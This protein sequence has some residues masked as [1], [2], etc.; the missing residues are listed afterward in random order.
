MQ[1]AHSFVYY[2]LEVVDVGAL[3]CR[4][5]DAIVRQLGEPRCLEFIETDVLAC[6]G[7]EVILFLLHI[8]K[9]IHLIKDNHHRLVAA[10]EVGQRF[11][12]D[13]NLILELG[14]RYIHHVQE[15]V[16]LTH[17][18]EGR[19]ER[20]NKVGGQ[21]AYETNG[22]GKQERKVLYN[23]LAHR[24][25]ER[26]KQFV[27]GKHFTLGKQV[28]KSGFTHVGIAHKRHANKTAAVLALNGL[29]AVYLC[30]LLLEERHTAQDYTAVHFELRLTRTAK[31]HATALA[32][33]RAT[34]LTFQV[35][36]QALQAWKHIFVLRQL[37]LH[38]G[39]GGLRT[40]SKDIQDER[41][42]VE[43]LYFK[44]LFDVAQLLGRQLVVED[45]HTYLL[46]GILAHLHIFGYLYELTTA[47]VCCRVRML[48]ALR[49]TFYHLGTCSLSKKF[50]LVEV[51]VGFALVLCGC[52]EAHKNGC[53]LFGG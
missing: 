51:L 52:Y 39:V 47:N 8:C 34:T 1:F 18:V 17:L 13:G 20:L 2:I 5:E 42:A 40:H 9:G 22:V 43:Y 12:N 46:I 33:T 37:H 15:E 6:F 21:L 19:F 27:F 24:G 10:V 28:H 31:A 16:G 7:S 45:N 48:Q 4:Y 30:K 49:K 26:C 32:T 41:C 23:N 29:L 53:L 25:V 14:V 11:V 44:F 38:L 36:P 35:G 50:K 3:T